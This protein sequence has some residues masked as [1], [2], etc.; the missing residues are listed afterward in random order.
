MTTNGQSIIRKTSVVHKAVD[1]FIDVGNLLLI[2]NGPFAENVE[3]TSEALLARARDNAQFL[4]NRIWELEK[5]RVEEA[6]VVTLPKKLYRIPREKPVP[7]AR[8]P[9]KWE[10]FAEAKGIVKKKKDKKAY[11]ESTGE[12]KPTWGYNRGKDNTK[13]WLIEV[14]GNKDPN[15]DYFEERVKA[16]KERVAKNETQRLKNIARHTSQPGKN[17]GPPVNKEM[18][19][20]GVEPMEKSKNELREA[21]DRAK[22]AT[23]SVGKFQDKIK[24]E[25]PNTKKGIKRKFEANIGERGSEKERN[26]NILQRLESKK[27]KLDD[28]QLASVAG[29][30]EPTERKKMKE[31]P[32]MKSQIHRQQ[33]YQKSVKNRKSKD[34]PRAG[35][36]KGAR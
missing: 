9:T 7:E 12:W 31:K 25:K 21:V 6:I 23:A 5:E 35:K 14:P 8:A 28:G 34:D 30:V 36:G 2:D 22:T 27:P 11:D 32:R 10:Q 1:P 20:V 19:G 33:F 3:H 24:G 26:K 29:N 4:F 15:A 13:D 18:I 17:K 16:K